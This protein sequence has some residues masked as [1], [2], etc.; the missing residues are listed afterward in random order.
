MSSTGTTLYEAV[1]GDEYFVQ[2]IDRFFDDVEGNELIRAMYPRSLKESRFRTWSFLAQYW[3]GPQTY[4]E[5]RGHPRLRMR[6]MPFEIGSAERDAWF[7]LMRTAV[8]ET[9]LPAGLPPEAVE[10]I[11]AMQIQYFEHAA[12][13]MVNQ[14]PPHPMATEPGSSDK[15]TEQ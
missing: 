12:S 14:M 4:S 3:G 10:E 13:A 11:R 7:E 1:G 9:P 5:K 6:H 15:N 8:E 2:L